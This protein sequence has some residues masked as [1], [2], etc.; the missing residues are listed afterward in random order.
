[1]GVPQRQRIGILR[2]DRELVG[3]RGRRAVAKAAAAV[4]PAQRRRRSPACA[5]AERHAPRAA[6]TAN[7]SSTDG[8]AERRQPQPQSEPG[9]RQEK[10]DRGRERRQ[11]RPQPFPEDGPA[12]A[13]QRRREQRPGRRRLPA[14]ALPGAGSARWLPS[15]RSPSSR[16]STHNN[17]LTWSGM[18][19]LR[20]SFDPSH[21]FEHD[22]YPKTGFHS[23]GS[24]SDNAP[25]KG[26]F[27]G[28]PP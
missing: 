27:K 3:D 23:S 26:Q 7:A 28:V 1:M 22:P 2:R 8:A 6:S 15:P 20:T 5:E 14:A 16:K 9:Q 12:R 17:T 4:E 18:T 13:P 19:F 10:P 25:P 21:S 24:C 11:R